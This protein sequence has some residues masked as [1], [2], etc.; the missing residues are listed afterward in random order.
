MLIL[1]LD[2]IRIRILYKDPYVNLYRDWKNWE[3]ELS[4]KMWREIE[5]FG[6]SPGRFLWLTINEPP[7][8]W[9]LSIPLMEDIEKDSGKKC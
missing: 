7:Y 4:L 5:W 2:E 3:E 6:E 9:A 8:I 1:D